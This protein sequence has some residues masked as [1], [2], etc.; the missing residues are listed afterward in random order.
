MEKKK[1]IDK[2]HYI[3]H[4]LANYPIAKQVEDI[5]KGGCRWVQLRMKNASTEERSCEALVI[6]PI[7]KRYGARLIINDD[8]LV[9][10]AIDSDGVHLGQDD[11]HPL[12]ARKR[13]GPDKIIGCTANTLA[14]VLR[15]S[16]YDIDYIGLGPFRFTTTKEKLSPV[17]GSEGIQRIVEQARA[18]GIYLPFIAIG[19]IRHLTDVVA[20][21]NTGA[22]GVAVSGGIHQAP[23]N[24]LACKAIVEAIES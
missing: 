20:L 1:H 18:S 14:D 5:C 23:D 19:G 10:K 6:Q 16:Q 9:A 11:M 17:L 7:L 3:T 2:L 15:L 4:P 13:L 24:V 12:E 21:T 22:Y 8:V